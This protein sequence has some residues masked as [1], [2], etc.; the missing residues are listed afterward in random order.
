MKVIKTAP[1]SW[2]AIAADGSRLSNGYQQ[3]TP[4]AA[5]R[6]GERAIALESTRQLNGD[7]AAIASILGG[8][9]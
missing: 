6:V 5:R 2:T 3:T 4:A 1:R 7:S 8:L 9:Y